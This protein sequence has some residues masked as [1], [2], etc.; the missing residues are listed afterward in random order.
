M[1][2]KMSLHTDAQLVEWSRNGDRTAFAT[3][4]KKYQSL[5]CSITYNATGSLSLSEDLAQETFFAAWKQLSELREPA[6]LRSWLCG[7]TRFLVG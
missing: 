5:V 7:I 3:I 6:R 4:V 1:T 2:P